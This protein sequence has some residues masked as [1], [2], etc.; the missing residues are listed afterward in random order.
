MF[1]HSTSLNSESPGQC[2]RKQNRYKVKAKVFFS[3]RTFWTHGLDIRSVGSI[4]NKK[5]SYSDLCFWKTHCTKSNGSYQLK[6]IKAAFHLDHVFLA[7]PQHILSHWKTS[8]S[9]NGTIAST[10]FTSHE[11]VPGQYWF[12]F[13]CECCMSCFNKT[14]S[15][16]TGGMRKQQ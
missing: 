9:V 14:E 3:W 16:V 8:A 7:P 13:S 4:N 1:A 11:S 15:N 5:F 12:D 2:L 6:L 10:I